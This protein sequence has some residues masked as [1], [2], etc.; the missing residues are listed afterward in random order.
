LP[1]EPGTASTLLLPSFKIL[2]KLW[3]KENGKTIKTNICALMLKDGYTTDGRI[4]MRM[5]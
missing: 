4:R 5:L 1:K 2:G 3:G